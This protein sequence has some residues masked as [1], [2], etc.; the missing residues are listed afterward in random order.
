VVRLELIQLPGA[1]IRLVF[2]LVPLP[3]KSLNGS[4]GDLSRN[5]PQST[6]S[7][8]VVIF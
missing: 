5:L 7:F 1:T 3:R 6:Q 2:V 4:S 8:S